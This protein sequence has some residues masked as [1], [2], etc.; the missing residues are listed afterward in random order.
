MRAVRARIAA[1]VLSF[2][3][4]CAA[5]PATACVLSPNYNDYAR[6]YYGSVTSVY[7]AVAEDFSAKDSRYPGNDFS[8]RLRPVEAIWGAPPPGPLKLEF[9]AG[10]CVDWYLETD[11]QDRVIEGKEYFVFVA[12]P[13]MEPEGI[14]PAHSRL[15]THPATG[16]QSWEAMVLL[17]QLQVTGDG[18]PAPPEQFP[19]LYPEGSPLEK[20]TL[21]TRAYP[22][23]WAAGAAGGLFILGLILGRA[24]R[25]RDKERKNP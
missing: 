7:R 2:S 6:A 5:S 8:A 10:T 16:R 18:P 11:E 20:P 24:I 17:R 21:W 14:F 23:P 4:L 9:T 1:V 3:A 15:R 13:G 12:P 25:P 22:W 19:G